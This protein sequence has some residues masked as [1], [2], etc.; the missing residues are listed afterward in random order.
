M[1]KVKILP[2]A[3]KL[4][5]KLNTNFT[6]E[7]EWAIDYTVCSLQEDNAIVYNSIEERFEKILFTKNEEGEI[8]EITETSVVC[9]LMLEENDSE[10]ASKLTEE[11]GSFSKVQEALN[12]NATTI[13]TL[14]KEK[15]EFERKK[16][17]F[18]NNISTL[19]IE[20]DSLKIK[21]KNLR[22][23]IWIILN[24]LKLLLMKKMSWLSSERL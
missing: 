21:I 2:G 20:N 16:V 10:V 5:E 11:L 7:Q 9:A 6:E 24:K 3:E 13:E 23:A 22:K 17:E 8:S 4:W 18:E 15:S 12:E 14:S 1:F 19:T